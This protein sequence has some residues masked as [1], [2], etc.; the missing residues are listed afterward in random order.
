MFAA[1]RSDCEVSKSRRDSPAVPSCRSP[2]ESSYLIYSFKE[3]LRTRRTHA[4]KGPVR[5][6]LH[7]TL[8]SCTSFQPSLLAQAI[9]SSTVKIV[10]VVYSTELLAGT[11]HSLLHFNHHF[12]SVG[13]KRF[14]L[15]GRGG[16]SQ[17]PTSRAKTF[18]I[19]ANW[20]LPPD[21]CTEPDLSMTQLHEVSF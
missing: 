13:S 6:R 7:E 16:Q 5:I 15:G 18:R 2:S 3:K 14:L 10:A 11:S 20:P 12:P 9:G 8:A 19:P 1:L 17:Q 21:S 4:S